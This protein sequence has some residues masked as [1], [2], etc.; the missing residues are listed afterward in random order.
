MK[1]E[2]SKTI[3]QENIPTEWALHLKKTD[4]DVKNDGVQVTKV[5]IP[6]NWPGG[7]HEHR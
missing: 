4:V 3:K 7:T 6:A 2:Q 5:C 1:T